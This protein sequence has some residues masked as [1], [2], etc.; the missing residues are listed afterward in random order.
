MLRGLG[1]L[2]G[3]RMAIDMSTDE[4]TVAFVDSALEKK[5]VTVHS[6]QC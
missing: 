1:F 6:E 5:G 3:K 4:C 2:I